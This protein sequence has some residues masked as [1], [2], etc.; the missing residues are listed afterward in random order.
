MV[1][2]IRNYAFISSHYYEE[3][4]EPQC[5]FVKVENT[6]ITD[7][8]PPPAFHDMKGG[9]EPRLPQCN[10][11]GLRADTCSHTVDS[12]VSIQIAI[13]CSW[14]STGVADGRQDFFAILELVDELLIE[15]NLFRIS[16]IGFESLS[17]DLAERPSSHLVVL[18]NVSD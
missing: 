17:H 8:L 18:I 5:R 7:S 16:S 9:Y 2:E 3:N 14:S 11:W 4:A 1:K 15:L 6:L 10:F 12:Q 13:L